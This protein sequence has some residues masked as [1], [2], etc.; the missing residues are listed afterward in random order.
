[1]PVPTGQIKRTCNEYDREIALT[2]TRQTIAATTSLAGVD[3]NAVSQGA[4]KLVVGSDAYT[5]FVAGTA[6][7]NA[8]VEVAATTAGP[9]TVINDSIIPAGGGS[10][11]I[12]LSGKEVQQEL[13]P[14]GAIRATLTLTGAAGQLVFDAYIAPVG[15]GG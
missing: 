11:D 9:W 5:G 12:L 2:S 8:A 13:D 1:M 15:H 6:E 4:Y 3:F 7:W 14:A 10:T